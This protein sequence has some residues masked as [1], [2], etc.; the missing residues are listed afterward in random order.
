LPLVTP[1]ASP[2]SSRDDD[3]VRARRGP[4]GQILDLKRV[5]SGRQTPAFA[6][7]HGLRATGTAFARRSSL[8][9]HIAPRLSVS[10]TQVT[11]PTR[12]WAALPARVR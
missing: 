12:A 1:A 5:A 8:T 7:V 9:R 10:I 3:Y 4:I 2:G 6:Q 11:D